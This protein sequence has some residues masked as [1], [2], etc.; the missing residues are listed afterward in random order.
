[1]N[2]KNEKRTFQSLRMKNNFLVK[3]KDQN[4]ILPKNLLTRLSIEK[5]VNRDFFFFF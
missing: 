1:M 4:S 2:F 3:F 5:L